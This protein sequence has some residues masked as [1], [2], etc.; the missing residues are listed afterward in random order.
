MRK[1]LLGTQIL[2]E[3]TICSR[4]GGFEISRVNSQIFH[5]MSS[6]VSFEISMVQDNG[7]VC[8]CVI[9]MIAVL[10]K[11]NINALSTNLSSQPQGP[12]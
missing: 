5:G 3:L 1:L 8:N 10:Q 12:C 2:F 4:Y 11:G 7:T 9:C 6:Q